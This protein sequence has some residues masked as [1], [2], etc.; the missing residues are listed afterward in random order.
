MVRWPNLS[1][2]A[3]LSQ[4][5]YEPG[6]TI[7][8]SA[9]LVEYDQPLRSPANGRADVTRPDGSLAIVGFASVGDGRYETAV[10][11]PQAGIY[12]FRI[13]ADG[14]TSR[15]RPFT[16]ERLRTAPI[17]AGGDEPPR[18]PNRPTDPGD[19]WCELIE[20]LLEQRVLPSA[21]GLE[22]IAESS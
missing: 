5:S 17:W 9:R 20:C 21:G 4:S 19:R 15:G 14:T 2:T 18:P 1:M 10:P 3:A 22:S 6:A 11:A 13:R 16:R 12:R 7:H 8:V